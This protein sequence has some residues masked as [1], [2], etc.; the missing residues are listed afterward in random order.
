MSARSLAAALAALVLST[1]FAALGFAQEKAASRPINPWQ[2]TNIKRMVAKLGEIKGMAVKFQTLDGASFTLSAFNPNLL[3]LKKLHVAQPKEFAAGEKVV[4][5]YSVP[6]P[7]QQKMLWVLMDPPS[8]ILLVEMR[9]KPVSAAFK[10]FA[11]ATR[12]LTVQVGGKTQVYTMTDPVM[13]VR[14]MSKATLGTAP[15]KGEKAYKAGDQML[16]IM[17]ADRKQVRLIM[18]QMTYDRY[19]EGGIRKF[20]VPPASQ[21]PKK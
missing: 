21:I 10:S 15:E 2:P 6:D 3:L 9:G 19:V 17:T 16:L 12:K 4:I 5:Y 20:P 18:D 11:P 13:A 8:E 1:A 14:K 7:K